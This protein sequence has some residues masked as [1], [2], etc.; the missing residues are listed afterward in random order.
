MAEQKPLSAWQWIL[1]M[2]QGTVIK[3]VWLGVTFFTLISVS[4]CYSFCNFHCCCLTLFQWFSLYQGSAEQTLA[5][6]RQC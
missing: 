4:M 3:R 6:N 2:F 5:F 1:K